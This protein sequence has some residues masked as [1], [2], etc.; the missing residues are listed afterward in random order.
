MY[1]LQA[2]RPFIDAYNL[3]VQTGHLQL[4]E[5]MILALIS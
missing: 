1:P 2:L 5:I 4:S 3:E